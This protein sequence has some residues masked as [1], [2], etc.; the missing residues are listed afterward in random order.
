MNDER[1]KK[2]SFEEYYV[3]EVARYP[4]Q[5]IMCSSWCFYVFL[6]EAALTRCTKSL[7]AQ[8]CGGGHATLFIS[9]FAGTSKVC[10][11]SLNVTN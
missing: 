4:A 3:V 5:R 11:G 10:L 9:K 1:E 8:Y 7:N 6:K 2:K